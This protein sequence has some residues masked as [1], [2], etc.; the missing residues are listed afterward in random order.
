MRFGLKVA[1]PGVSNPSTADPRENP[2]DA[3][4]KN[5]IFNTDLNTFKYVKK[6]RMTIRKGVYGAI[7]TYEHGLGY[8][9]S[10]IYYVQNNVTGEIKQ[11]NYDAGSAGAIV[12]A[13]VD[14]KNIYFLI[15][16]GEVDQ[17]T[18]A[19][20]PFDI[21]YYIGADDLDDVES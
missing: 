5:L 17:S 2:T 15:N 11:P 20:Q 18:F 4:Q 13:Y 8:C 14:K 21:I 9:P 3:G 6:G 19:D 12:I 1:K 16:A 7:H 10:F